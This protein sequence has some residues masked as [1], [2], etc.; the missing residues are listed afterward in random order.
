M[1]K[2]NDKPASRSAKTKNQQRQLKV[3]ETYHSY[4]PSQSCHQRTLIGEIHLKG[5]WLI[6][7]GFEIDSPVKVRVMEG[8]LVLTSEPEKSS[9]AATEL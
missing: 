2:G 5:Q 4:Q 1:T 3:R 7:A 9:P 6:K 8:Y